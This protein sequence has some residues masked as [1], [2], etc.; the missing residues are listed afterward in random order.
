MA[1]SAEV[2]AALAVVESHLSEPELLPVLSSLYLRCKA[3]RELVASAAA[4]V[5]AVGRCRFECADLACSGSAEIKNVGVNYFRMMC[6]C[7]PRRP[8][9]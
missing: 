9:V 6:F 2:V 8:C 7:I 5:D 3:A 1:L 4:S